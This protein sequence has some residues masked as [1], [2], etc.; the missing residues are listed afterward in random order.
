MKTLCCKCQASDRR[1]P[2]PTGEPSSRCAVTLRRPEGRSAGGKSAARTKGPRTRSRR[3][4][5]RLVA[6]RRRLTAAAAVLDE[7]ISAPVLFEINHTLATYHSDQ[8]KFQAF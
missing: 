8:A 1:A 6:G 3:W 5:W 2:K 7:A 4:R